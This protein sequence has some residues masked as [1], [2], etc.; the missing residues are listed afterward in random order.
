MIQTIKTRLVAPAFEDED[1]YALAQTLNAVLLV[2]IAGLVVS[3]AIVMLVAHHPLTTLT[4]YGGLSL[5]MALLLLV[6]RRGYVRAA[7]VLLVIVGW[8]FVTGANISL[9]GLDSP[10]LSA[11][12]L[13]IIVAGLLL[14]APGALGM[15]AV[16]ALTL[17][18]LYLAMRSDLLNAASFS[19]PATIAV[20][21]SIY[22][23]A[24]LF[25]YIPTRSLE[26]AYQ[27]T[28]RNEE[29]LRQT[30]DDL[31]ST[32]VSKDYVNNIIQSMSN[33]LIVMDPDG[34]IRSV[35]RATLDLLGYTEEELVGQHFNEAILANDPDRLST[36]LLVQ[37]QVTRN[38]NQYF[39]AKDGRLIPVS[40]SSSVMYHELG[41]A[42]GV[43]AVAQD[44]TE[45]QQIEEKLQYQADLL[46]N[47]SDAIIAT[48]MDLTI[49]SWNAAAEQVYGWTASE[50]IGKNLM[51]VV[52]TSFEDPSQEDLIKRQYIE[53]GHWQ[54]E[55][56]QRRKDGRQL[57]VLSSIS[58]LRSSEGKPVGTVTVN[59]DIT[60]RKLA[61]DELKKHVDQLAALRHVD[62]EISSILDLEQV[63]TVA[64]NAAVTLAGADDGF[65]LLFSEEVGRVLR[66]SGGYSDF[67]FDPTSHL[68]SIAGQAMEDQQPRLVADVRADPAQADL[69]PDARAVMSFPLRFHERAVGIIH[70]ET[71]R[72]GGFTPERFDFMKLL[73]SRIAAA[74][75]NARLYQVSQRHL[76]ELQQ[77]YTQVSSLEQLKTDMIRIASHDLRNPVGIINGYLELMR[78]DVADRLDDNE[79]EYLDGIGDAVKRMQS[80]VT[81]ILSLERIQ[82]VAHKPFS[83]RVDMAEL[84]ERVVHSH[85]QE[86]EKKHLSLHLDL[87][88]SHQPL[89]VSGDRPQLFE[90]TANLLTNA[91]KYTPPGGEIVVEVLQQG[92]WAA[93]VVRDTG[94][95]IPEGQQ[96][97]LFQPFYRAQTRETSAI[98]GL[99]LGLH[100]VKNIVERHKGRMLF[101]STYGE[102]S[103]FGFEL[104]LIP[105][106]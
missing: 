80:I 12:L 62:L 21:I 8:A 45:R 54:S 72:D 89:N 64:L 68:P 71:R 49:T 63:T 91:I 50:V 79:R 86:A 27:R 103:L 59:Y 61:E 39:S 44:E 100:L 97:R 78:L 36:T 1:Q 92:R 43:V 4:F 47:V 51:Q 81:D 40:L 41:Y 55:V 19:Q 106:V 66:V 57:Y 85:A 73:V 22:V 30:L 93:L 14:G 18:G 24:A 34:T 87:R 29:A 104:P 35:N 37:A 95:G 84:A 16:N 88:P 3:A 38:V 60:Q 48:T 7:T 102:G 83:D 52:H 25:L 90:A 11:Y 23:L 31:Q 9:G 42:L 20:N 6:M 96:Q 82:Q 15:L 98:D 75:D 69:L 13:T 67:A 5:A 70:L 101:E 94:Y 58:L 2:G 46:E 17:L 26:A 28:R 77:L 53:R 99:G 65:L 105:E 32:T 74:V 33:L 56:V 76:A 10:A